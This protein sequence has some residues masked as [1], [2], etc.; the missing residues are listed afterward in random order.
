[1]V[2]Q[3]LRL[4]L[5]MQEVWVPSLVTCI[6]A[7]KPEHKQEKPYCNK[8]NK[9]FIIGTHKKKIFKKMLKL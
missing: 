7:K 1:M 8:F 5:S 3:W 2:V 6:K 4:C 9:D